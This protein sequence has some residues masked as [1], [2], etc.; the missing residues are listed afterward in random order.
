ML[1]WST[2]V[3]I[4][5]S[6]EPSDRFTPPKY[7]VMAAERAPT[8]P[9]CNGPREVPSDSALPMLRRTGPGVVAVPLV[10]GWEDD[11][12]AS[13]TSGWFV[14]VRTDCACPCFASLG[15]EDDSSCARTEGENTRNARTAKLA[16]LTGK[17]FASNVSMKPPSNRLFGFPLSNC[18]GSRNDDDIARK[19][20]NIVLV[21]PS[22]NGLLVVERNLY[23]FAVHPTQHVDLVGLGKWGHAA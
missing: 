12:P 23:R 10:D 22:H 9:Q 20:H 13:T 15:F 8:G 19:Q 17:R 18:T 21:D 3:L 1:V 11:S 5:W 16:Q 4:H 2:V 7:W 6:N 14:A